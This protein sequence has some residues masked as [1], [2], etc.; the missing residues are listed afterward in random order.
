[1]AALHVW[2]ALGG[3][4]SVGVLAGAAF[5]VSVVS[6]GPLGDVEFGAAVERVVP[7]SESS[8]VFC[9]PVIP[10]VVARRARVW[11][12]NATAIAV[13]AARSGVQCGQPGDLQ[14]PRRQPHEPT[15]TMPVVDRST[16]STTAPL[17]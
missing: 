3:S 7:G 13:S 8:Q 15:N 16:C 10:S 11:P 12:A 14:Q 1:M 2:C 17:N 6:G 5:R 4:V 9:V